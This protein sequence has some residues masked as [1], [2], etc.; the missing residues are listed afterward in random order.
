MAATWLG[1]VVDGRRRL[2]CELAGDRGSGEG[3]GWFQS[4]DGDVGILGLT[5]AAV[6][7]EAVA[8]NED[9]GGGEVRARGGGEF[10]WPS[11]Q[12]NARTV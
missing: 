11:G 1:H 8:G 7:R 3:S 4:H 6:G 2:G 12:L 9:E 10:R 5:T